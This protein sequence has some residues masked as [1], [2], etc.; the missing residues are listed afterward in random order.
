MT[1]TLDGLRLSPLT[2]E[3][4]ERIDAEIPAAQGDRYDAQGMTAVNI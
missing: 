3:D 4:L 1:E 2:D